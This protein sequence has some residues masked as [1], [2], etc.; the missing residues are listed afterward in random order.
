MA[1]LAAAKAH[2]KVAGAGTEGVNDTGCP[3]PEARIAEAANTPLSQGSP[4]G[5]ACWGSQSHEEFGNR[6]HDSGRNCNSTVFIF[7]INDEWK[8]A[9]RLEESCFSTLQCVIILEES[10]IK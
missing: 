7:M 1:V 10:R 5:K 3:G 4:G 9:N 6:G 8:L 2:S